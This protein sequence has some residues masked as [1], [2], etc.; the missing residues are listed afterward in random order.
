M[1]KLKNSVMKKRIKLARKKA[2]LKQKELARKAKMT[3]SAI[4]NYE[5]GKQLPNSNA[6]YKL[7]QV[8]EVS[9]NYL[10][11]TTDPS[12][13]QDLLYNQKIAKLLRDYMKLN[14]KE[15]FFVKEYIKQ[16]LKIKEEK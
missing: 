11:G 6:L 4:C 7:S 15:K 10:M 12:E 1:K 13:F 9:V 8:L 14:R 5:K 3:E 2:G 16:A